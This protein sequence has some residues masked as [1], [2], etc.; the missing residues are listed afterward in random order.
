MQTRYG[1]P[2]NW[3]VDSDVMATDDRIATIAAEG[4]R[5]IDLARS[6]PETVVPQYPSWTLRDLALH[7]ATVHGRTAGICRTL[8]QEGID[9][10]E[11]PSGMDPVDWAQ[12]A[13][14]DLVQ[15]LSEADPD[16]LV[17]TFG[18]DKRLRFWV[19]R[20]VIETG[21]HRWDAEAAVER[22]RPLLELVAADGL[23]EFTDF[24]LGRLGDVPT[25]ELL[26][27][28]LDRSWRYGPGDPT[29]L[30]RGTAS[31]L[32]LRL[33]SRPGTPL[34]PQWEAAVDALATPAA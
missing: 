15:T 14:K 28:D 1:R 23:D 16:A 22:P 27:T 11:L 30:V 17:W 31:D 7:V 18:T 2:P 34:P 8:A 10:P 29:A 13:L 25:I 24:Y 32:F 5:I 19:R 4:Q 9:T 3:L 20:M 6:A 33:M 12:L 26:A 21:V